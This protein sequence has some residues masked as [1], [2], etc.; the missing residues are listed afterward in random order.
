[1]VSKTV[2]SVTSVSCRNTCILKF[3]F[4][5]IK[6]THNQSTACKLFWH[7]IYGIYGNFDTDSAE[8]FSAKNSIMKNSYIIKYFL[9]YAFQLHIKTSRRI[10]Q[11]KYDFW[12][13]SVW[14]YFVF[15][16]FLSYFMNSRLQVYIWRCDDLL[17]SPESPKSPLK[18]P[19]K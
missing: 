1:M 18:S 10:S 14:D 12:I 8:L 2:D 11:W 17:K 15:N 5:V 19:Q 9:F 13:F 7:S 16:F 4:F 3:P 6:Y